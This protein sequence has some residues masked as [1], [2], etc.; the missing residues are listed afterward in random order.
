MT[1]RE[2]PD[3]SLP[4]GEVLPKLRVIRRRPWWET[5]AAMAVIVV[6]LVALAVLI[7]TVCRK[8]WI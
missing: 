7:G 4:N 2:R 8:G 6:A 3:P 1:E 5:E